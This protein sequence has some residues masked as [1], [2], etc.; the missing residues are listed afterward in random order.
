MHQRLNREA[1]RTSRLLDFCSAKELQAQTG[2]EMA[3]WPLVIA[4][5]GVDNALDACEDA[6]IAPAVAIRVD[7]D[8]ITIADNG[9]GI[10]TTTVESVL[11]FNVRVSSR[12][13]YVSPTRGAQGNALKTLVAMPYVL[14]GGRLGTATISAHGMQ[15]HIDF[16]VDQIRQQPA[17]TYRTSPADR[18][19]GTEI[20]V[21]WP[22]LACS[23]LQQ[24]RGRFLQIVQDYA[25]LNPNL[26]LSIDWFGEVLEIAPTDSTWA[27][28][29]ASDPTSPHW[30]PPERQQRLIAAQVA[31]DADNGRDR[32]V[33]EFVAQFRGLS[34]TGKQKAVL[35][36]LCLSRAALCT[37]KQWRD[38]RRC[39]CRAV[40]CHEVA[41][42][43]DQAQA[44]RRH[45]PQP[46]RT[47]LSRARL[48][49]G[50]LR[51]SQD[52][53]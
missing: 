4:K 26:T 16:R 51:L 31:H 52:R 30:Y 19:I 20:R 41:V 17:I 24:S 27:K 29:K 47:S 8:G 18:K 3:D 2:H 37:R 9:P 12:E 5:E 14:S 50:V 22:D 53:G 13:A 45:R 7:A 48:R 43:A 46:F 21:G 33:R 10:P 11:D 28:W 44:S 25:W 34:S 39:H 15:H 23:I 42:E 40:R 36:A 6:D 49:N 1:F 35:E 32:T 38:R